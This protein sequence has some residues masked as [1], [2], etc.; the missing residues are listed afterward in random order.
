[1]ALMLRRIGSYLALTA[2]VLQIALAFG[3]FHA[4]GSVRP[5]AARAAGTELSRPLPAQ[6]P[7]DADEYCAICASIAV[8]SSTSVPDAPQLPS[9]ADFDRID[10][11]P[12]AAISSVFDA[13]RT[14]FQSRAPPRA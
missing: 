6:L 10:R 9:P 8:A 5:V 1:M 13:R 3:H 4:D 2:L 14:P 11:S 12:V 7:G